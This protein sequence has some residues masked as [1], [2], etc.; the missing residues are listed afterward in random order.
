MMN[1][2]YDVLNDAIV[3]YQSICQSHSSIANWFLNCTEYVW[4]SKVCVFKKLK[5]NVTIKDT[6]LGNRIY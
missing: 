3:K 1:E 5:L 2:S 4:G 6:A